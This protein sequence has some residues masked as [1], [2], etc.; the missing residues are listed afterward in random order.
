MSIPQ[1]TICTSYCVGPTPSSP[2][3]PCPR[4]APV[5][6]SHHTCV[7]LPLRG[8]RERGPWIC[9]CTPGM[10]APLPD[11]GSGWPSA[12]ARPWP[13]DQRPRP[14]S[15]SPLRCPGPSLSSLTALTALQPQP[16]P[17]VPVRAAAGERE[18]GPT[19][20]SPP[21]AAPTGHPPPTGHPLGP[22]NLGKHKIRFRHQHHFNR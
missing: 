2:P 5:F 11:R 10:V 1:S 13:W 21:C 12:P 8:P 19:A 22:P 17:G 18:A 16:V 9:A 3:A 20:P 7:P 14:P 6:H 15:S 4:P